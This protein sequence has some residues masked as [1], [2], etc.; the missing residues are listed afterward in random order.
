MKYK[1][2]KK[3]VASGWPESVLIHTDGASRGNPGPASTGIAV[4][5]EKGELFYEEASALGE[6]TN[7]YAEYSAVLKALKLST[8]NKIKSLILKSDSEFLIKQLQGL[9][10]V[11]SENIKSLYKNCKL[12]ESR[13]SKV[14]FQHVRREYNKKADELA[15]LILDDMDII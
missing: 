14:E 7:N 2:I 8:A 11:R 3:G 1:T 13:I 15:N 6:Q 12:Y 10:K 5:D 4:Y 9:Y